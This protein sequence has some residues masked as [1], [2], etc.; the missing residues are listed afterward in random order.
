VP[1]LLLV[2]G[3]V[4]GLLLASVARPLVAVGA[5]R[6]AG[7]AR[8]RLHERVREVADEEVLVPLEATRA[9]HDRFRA[10]VARAAS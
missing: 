5:R 4:A 7:V 10:A 3:L 8:R 9:E 1:T 2:A 6:R